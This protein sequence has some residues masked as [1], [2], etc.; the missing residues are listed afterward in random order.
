M[1]ATFEI[2]MQFK[3][4]RDT[5]KS[6]WSLGDL[7]N[8]YKFIYQIDRIKSNGFMTLLYKNNSWDVSANFLT[9]H[10]TFIG[11]RE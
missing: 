9:E 6:N 3:L 10:F 1:P 2:G 11:D 4:R 8:K 5:D 7:E